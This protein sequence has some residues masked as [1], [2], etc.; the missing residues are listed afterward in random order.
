MATITAIAPIVHPI[1][2]GMIAGAVVVALG[3]GP[4]SV[5]SEIELP[6]IVAD[7]VISIEVIEVIGALVRPPV[8]LE[9][10]VVCGMIAG[11]VVVASGAG[12]MSAVSEIEL[13]VIVAEV[14]IGIEVIEVIGAVR[15]VR[16]LVVLGTAAAFERVLVQTATAIESGNM[17]NISR[18]YAFKRG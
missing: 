4:M 2:C 8:A 16:P 5:G 9:T 17:A 10:D 14:V 6:V 13:P 1:V 15:V 7:V 12:L 18:L 11:A 3:T